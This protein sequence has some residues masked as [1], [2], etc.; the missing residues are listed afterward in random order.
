MEMSDRNER[1]M[2]REVLARLERVENCLAMLLGAG[3]RRVSDGSTEE[4][5]ARVER[6]MAVAVGTLAADDDA[7]GNSADEPVRRFSLDS[8]CV[9]T[10]GR[11]LSRAIADELAAI[12][13]R[14]AWAWR[15]V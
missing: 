14:Y 6:Q 11:P 2:E 8:D 13:R 4:R 7:K 10:G 1:V 9:D 15:G 5:L 3:S 12:E